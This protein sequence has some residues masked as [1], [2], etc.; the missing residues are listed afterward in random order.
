MP[1]EPAELLPGTLDMMVLQVVSV[2]PE[3]GFGIGRRLQE[4]SHGVF[5]V[6]QGSLY[7]ALQRLLQRGWIT[8][9]WRQTESGRRARYYRITRSGA[10]QLERERGS[11]A[12]Q[13]AAVQLV[14]DWTG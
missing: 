8:G 2:G 7:P 14:L 10:R 5:D 13:I 9:E 1:K 6:N 4:V 11:F 12:R 3:H